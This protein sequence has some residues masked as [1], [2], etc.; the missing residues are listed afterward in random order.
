MHCQFGEFLDDSLSD[1]NVCRLQSEAA[2]KRLL[3]ELKLTF[4]RAVE[5]AQGMEKAA[6]QAHKLQSPSHA[7]SQES[8]D[9]CKLSPVATNAIGVGSQI[10]S[11]PSIL[12]KVQSAQL[13]LLGDGPNLL[14][15]DWLRV[16]RLDWKAICQESQNTWLPWRKFFRE[17]RKPAFN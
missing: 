2:Q 5:I 6:N 1:R 9:V 4:Q 11:P 3:I 7:A 17:W 8:K 14:G 12:S 15:R 16:I 10:I 13:P